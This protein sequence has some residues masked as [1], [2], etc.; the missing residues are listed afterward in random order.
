MEVA[1]EAKPPVCK[2]MDFGKWKYE[3][4]MKARDQRR[5]QANTQLKEIRFRLKIDE[6]DY[7]TKLGHARRFL[8]GGDKV[9]AM[10]QFRG[11]EQSR[12]ELGL[13]LL[14][15]LAEDAAE[16][17]VIESAPQQD[18]RNMTMVLGP[19]KKKTDA[20]SAQR[21]RRDAER[22]A[23]REAKANRAERNAAKVAQQAA[24]PSET[25][26]APKPAPKTAAKPAALA[27]DA[28]KA[29]KTTKTAAKP[30]DKPAKPRATTKKTT[31]S[32]GARKSTAKDK[33]GNKDA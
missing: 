6:H 28:E 17:G 23:R 22:A 8:D 32:A 9:K 12:P 7:Q 14:E 26:P 10:I 21:R 24:A 1:P 30:A 29:A 27:G 2:L 15:R 19:I 11:R 25:Q 5:N 4:A 18:G 16:S 3:A 31:P 20:K 33:E 13:K